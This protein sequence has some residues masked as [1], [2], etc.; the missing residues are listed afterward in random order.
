MEMAKD[1]MAK[2]YNE[3]KKMFPDL[4]KGQEVWLNT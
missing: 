3:G 2:S 1:V 4:E